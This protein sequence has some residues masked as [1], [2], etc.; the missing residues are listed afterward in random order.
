[1]DELYQAIEEKIKAAGYPREI[2]GQAVYE[3]TFTLEKLPQKNLYIDLGNVMVMAKVT[4]NGQYVGGV[5]TFPYRLN[6]T[7]Y[8]KEGENKLEI[9]V[10]NNWQNRLIGDQRLP[11]DQRLTWTTINPW[12]ADSSTW[13]GILHEWH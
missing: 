11:E 10:V 3:T 12:K 5:W 6:V 2:S 4:L 9:T 13:Y 1:M 8:L 7:G